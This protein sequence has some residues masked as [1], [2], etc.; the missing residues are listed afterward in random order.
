MN[1][2]FIYWAFICYLNIGKIYVVGGF[3]GIIRY[4]SVECYDL[5]IDRWIIVGEM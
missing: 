5:T 2:L 1:N 3:D 4:I